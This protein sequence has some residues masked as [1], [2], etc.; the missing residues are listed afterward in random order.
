VRFDWQHSIY[1]TL[2]VT[3]TLCLAYRMSYEKNACIVFFV[4][5]FGLGLVTPTQRQAIQVGSHENTTVQCGRIIGPILCAVTSSRR[6]AAP[7]SKT[8]A[9]NPSN[10]KES[11]MDGQQ[12][13]LALSRGQGELRLI[14]ESE[15]AWDCPM[16]FLE[17]WNEGW[18]PDFWVPIKLEEASALAD[19]LR[20][21]VTHAIC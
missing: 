17:V 18:K 10:T 21:H 16:L 3:H 1:D 20:S 6:Q 8:R 11:E 7:G 2:N 12:T 19:A 14:A 9:S 4:V 5:A 13:L 15:T